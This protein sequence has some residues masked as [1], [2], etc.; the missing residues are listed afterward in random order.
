MSNVSSL[1]T[2]I[3][4]LVKEELTDKSPVTLYHYAKSQEETLKLDPNRFGENSY[5]KRDKL[6]SDVPRVFFYLNPREKESF[7]KAEH[8]LYSV[9]VPRE[10]IYNVIKDPLGLKKKHFEKRPDWDALLQELSGYGWEN[11]KKMTKVREPL[12]KGMYYKPDFEVVIWFD[13]ITV[14]KVDQEV[15]S[16]LENAI[17]QS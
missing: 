15:R 2:L 9:E 14:R 16:S 6:M 12:F 1:K 17:K 5:T 13:Y 3:E 11:S 8:S 7:F 4:S 10:Q